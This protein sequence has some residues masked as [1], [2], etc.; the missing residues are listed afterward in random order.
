[1]SENVLIVGN[2]HV[3]SLYGAYKKSTKKN[4]PNFDFSASLNDEILRLKYENSI[5]SPVRHHSENF[6]FSLKKYSIIIILVD[7]GRIDSLAKIM[8][9]DFTDNVLELAI[10]YHF[11]TTKSYFLLE[12]LR[13]INPDALYYIFSI[14]QHIEKEYNIKN[15][16]YSRMNFLTGKALASCDCGYIP[17]S[18]KL[19]D[20]HFQPIK[21]YYE[22]CNDI[23]GEISQTQ[24]R[25]NKNH[26]NNEAG[27]LNMKQIYNE[28]RSVLKK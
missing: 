5:L 6:D 1:M 19:L 7:F 14:P 10:K 17:Q 16:A 9:G 22:K 3:G 28:I 12:T 11:Q 8:D 13:A 24:E 18:R 23:Y 2:S 15:E 21:K 25:H 20:K 4:F 26:L 27:I